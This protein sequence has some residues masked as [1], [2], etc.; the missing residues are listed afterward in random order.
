MAWARDFSPSAWSLLAE[1]IVFPAQP[2]GNAG[3]I[4]NAA[5]FAS[6]LRQLM[7]LCCNKQQKNTDVRACLP[8]RR[9]D[10]PGVTL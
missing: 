3:D 10:I 4:V 5:L 6:L 1:P 8:I 2:D 9:A 7:I